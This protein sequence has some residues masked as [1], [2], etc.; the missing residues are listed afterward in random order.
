MVLFSSLVTSQVQTWFRAVRDELGPDP[1]RVLRLG[2]A[3]AD[4]LRE[5]PHHMVRTE[6]R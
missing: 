4:L 1:G 5:A 3:L 6:A 2:A